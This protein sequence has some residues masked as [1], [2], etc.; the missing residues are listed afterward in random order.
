MALQYLLNVLLLQTVDIP[1]GTD[2]VQFRAILYLC[3]Y[4]SK[5]ITNLAQ[6]TNKLRGRRFHSTF[7]YIDD[8]CALNDG[9]EFGKDFLE[10]YPTELELKV[11]HN[12]SHK[13]FLD[14]DM[15]ISKR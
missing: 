8:L 1:I 4:D 5:Y 9:G 10:T 3:N 11:E 7:W 14:L 6:R 12:G 13:T 15:S 2:P